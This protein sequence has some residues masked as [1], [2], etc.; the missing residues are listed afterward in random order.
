MP[1]SAMDAI[2]PAFKHAKEQLFRPFRFGQWVRLALVGLLAG[3]LSS[4]GGGCN[5]NFNMPITHQP[6]G[7]E[8][9]LGGTLPEAVAQ[10]AAMFAW[11]LIFLILGGLVLM[12]ALM[13]VSSVMRFILFDSIVAKE[14]HIRSGWARR[15]GEGWRLFLWQLMLMAVTL[16][17]FLVLIGIPLLSAVAFGWFRHPGEHLLPLVLGGLLFFLIL[18]VLFAVLIAV[19]VM[20]KDFVVPQMAQENIGATEGWRRLWTWIMAE[21]GGYGAYVGMKVLLAIGAGIAFGIITLIAIVVL[22]IPIGGFGVVAVLAGKAAGLTWDFYTIG[23][24][25]IAGG[26]ALVIFMFV[27]SFISVPAMVFFPAYS[28][29]FFAPRYPALAKLLWPQAVVPTPSVLPP[30]EPPFPPPMMTPIG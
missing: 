22:L 5:S 25:V 2:S 15:R 20:T 16:A 14:C 9:F 23:L 30:T 1:I 10:H 4:G 7:S 11:L 8:Q 21:K 13:Y 12:V 29:Y 26:I 18:L 19:H 27:M 17:A 24:A 28:L 6:Q 3:E